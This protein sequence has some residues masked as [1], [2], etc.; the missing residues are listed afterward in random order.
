MKR[1]GSRRKWKV[2][3]PCPWGDL[4]LTQV[5]FQCQGD[6]GKARLMEGRVSRYFSLL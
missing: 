1:N 2:N 3:T 4:G 6:S 5:M